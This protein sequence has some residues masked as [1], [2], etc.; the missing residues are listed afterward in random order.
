MARR[1]ESLQWGACRI[2]G[3]TGLH[4]APLPPP[5]GTSASPPLPCPAPALPSGGDY[6][7]KELSPALSNRFTSI[8]VPAIEDGAELLAILESRL[9]GGWARRWRAGRPIVAACRG[10]M[11]L[12]HTLGRAQA[13]SWCFTNRS[14]HPPALHLA[15]ADAEAKALV[16]PRL[17][18]F[19]RFFRAEAA[20]AARQALSGE[21]PRSM[22]AATVKRASQVHLM[23][24]QTAATFIGHSACPPGVVNVLLPRHSAPQ[25]ATCWHGRASSMPPPRSWGRWPRM[26]TAPTWC[27]WTALAWG[28]ACLQRCGVVAGGDGWG[29]RLRAV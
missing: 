25:C 15:A 17:L 1:A 5:E 13:D 22:G 28:W 4:S 19:W 7:K 6:G 3:A 10:A 20:H 21:R 11:L 24:A 29:G 14:D 26:R 9:A 12:C 23:I 18:E 8:W 16:A 27:C 2:S